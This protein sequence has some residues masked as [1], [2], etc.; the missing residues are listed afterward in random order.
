GLRGP[1]RRICFSAS[2]A[3]RRAGSASTV[4]KA[5]NAGFHR[6]IR[7][8]AT[9]TSSTGEISLRRSSREACSI[10]RNASSDSEREVTR[11]GSE[12]FLL[13]PQ[14]SGGAKIGDANHDAI[15]ILIADRA[16]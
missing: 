11:F 4:R 13:A 7:A 6:S 12:D 1:P 9:S 10:E 14:V 2:F 16:E 8:S 15:L 5:S 3:C